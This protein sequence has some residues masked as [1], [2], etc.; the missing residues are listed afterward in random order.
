VKEQIIHLEPHDDVTSV[1][2]K[3]GWVRAPRVLLVF[4]DDPRERVLQRKL[5]LVLIQ[6]EATRLRAQLALVTSDP[7]IIEHARELGIA[8]FRSIEASQK[9]YWRTERARLKIERAE[10]PTRLDSELVEAATRFKPRPGGL[11]AQ[12]QRI[13]A[14]SLL[15][16]TATAFLIGAYLLLPS[17]T[18]YL[19]PAAN[20]V[21]V[22]TT[23]IAVPEAA[24]VDTASGTIP[25]RMVGVEVEGSAIVDTTGTQEEPMEKARGVALFSN[26]LPDQVTVPAG[27]IVR[28]SAAQPV[29]FVTLADA[30]LPGQIG[31]TVEVPIE[32]LEPGYEGNLP[33]NRINQI[34]GSLSSR[35]AVTNG[36]PTRGG[37][38]TEVRA[39][40]QEDY[41][42]VRALLMQKL[43]QR[44]FAEMQTSPY[45]DLQETEFIPLESLVIVLIDSE[46]YDGYVDQ[47]AEQV[48]LT[49]RATVQGTAIDERLARQVVYA[50]LA[51]KVGTGYQIG[52][53]S[54]IFRRGEVTGIGEQR[55]VTFIMQGAGDVSLAIQ[56]E[57]VREM[58]HGMAVSEALVRL[59]RELPL[60][61]PPVIE[62]WP[63][64]WPLMPSLP[65]RIQVE[66]SG[67]L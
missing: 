6:R 61:T 50:R 21:T 41:D 66:V 22:T 56:P 24:E 59:D 8:C 25:A 52:P 15:V 46:T 58:V 7:I 64:F 9:R 17:A 53:D 42:R 55:Q 19:T 16:I 62:V 31:E 10:Q 65:F 11:P 43:Q 39:I 47:S 37:D 60:A 51:D 4:P 54:L 67:Q 29:R 34:E 35:V 26:L 48:S 13:A 28:T 2:D 36:Q 45:I 1:R 20:Q 33:S 5:D 30:T 57:A 23:V 18:V 32:A 27:T 3:L 14:G 38:V 40:S 49:M 63:G 12:V 44:A